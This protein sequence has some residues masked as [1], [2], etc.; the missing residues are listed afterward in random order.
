MTVCTNFII[1]LFIIRSTPQTVMYGAMA[2][3]CLRS[4]QLGR[5][6]SHSTL[7]K[8]LLSFSDPTTTSPLHLD[9]RGPSINSWLTAGKQFSLL[10][11]RQKGYLV[12]WWVGK[13]SCSVFCFQIV[14]P[15]WCSMYT[16]SFFLLPPHACARGKA[17][18][19]VCCLSACLSVCRPHENRQITRSGHL[20]NS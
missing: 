13:T 8:R 4:G 1:R 10:S 17:I 2:W 6:H 14:D 9:A 15:C 7:I 11:Y 19:F 16:S 3:C 5:S 20:S 12:A 18:G